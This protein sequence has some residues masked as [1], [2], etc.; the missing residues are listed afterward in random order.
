MTWQ[1]ELFT[2]WPYQGEAGG[3][4]RQGG[5]E[6]LGVELVVALHLAVGARVEIE[7]KV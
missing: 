2:T 3:V 6:A 1:K 4:L 5:L 7:G